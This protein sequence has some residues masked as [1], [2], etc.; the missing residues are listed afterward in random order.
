[1]P[2]DF[3]P[4]KFPPNAFITQLSTVNQFKSKSTAHL[5]AYQA[6]SIHRLLFTS[7]KKIVKAVKNI[8]AIIKAKHIEI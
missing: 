1:M 5:Q 7:I 2:T 4:L 6:S 3:H 8:A